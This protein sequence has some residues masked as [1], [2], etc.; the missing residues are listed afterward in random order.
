MCVH[1]SNFETQNA[2][3]ISVYFLLVDGM[4]TRDRMTDAVYIFYKT[5]LVY[6]CVSRKSNL[7]RCKEMS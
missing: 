6:A 2:Q 1:I 7:T 5:P 4:Q 3:L